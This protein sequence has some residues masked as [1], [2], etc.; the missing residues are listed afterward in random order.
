MVL[1]DGSWC[2]EYH[3]K[4][5]IGYLARYVIISVAVPLCR[6]GP[7]TI[8]RAI[9]Q[10]SVLVLRFG[11]SANQTSREYSDVHIEASAFR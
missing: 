10:S 2:W 1:Q 4:E 9:P 6:S 5:V 7:H 3:G 8:Y 11:C